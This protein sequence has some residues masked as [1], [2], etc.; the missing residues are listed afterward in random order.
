MLRIQ[1]IQR[2]GVMFDNTRAGFFQVNP[3]IEGRAGRRRS[4]CIAGTFGKTRGRTIEL[5]FADPALRRH[6]MSAA[7][8]NQRAC[9][10]RMDVLQRMAIRVYNRNAREESV[11]IHVDIAGRKYNSGRLCF[12]CSTG[13]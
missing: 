11:R 3:A 13:A 2:P 1:D 10:L 8:R 6:R 7:L 4:L 5:H 9:G 12:R